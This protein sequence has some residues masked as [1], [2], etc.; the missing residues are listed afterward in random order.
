MIYV[1]AKRWARD[2]VVGRPVVQG[3]VGSLMGEGANKGVL[4]TTS[5]F[6]REAIEYA[7]SI[8]NLKIILMDGGAVDPTDD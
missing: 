2:N 8:Q 3:F 1:Q 5:R 7:K 4:I 6:S